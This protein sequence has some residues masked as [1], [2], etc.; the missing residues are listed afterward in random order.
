MAGFASPLGDVS[1]GPSRW[2]AHV[3]VGPGVSSPSGF[4]SGWAALSAEGRRTSRRG[5]PPSFPWG[6]RSFLAEQVL[7]D[8]LGGVAGDGEADADGA[9]GLARGGDRG[10]D[11]HELA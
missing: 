4:G 3:G 8:G 7:G 5:A 2:L 1:P 9:G 10:V 11:A 6:K